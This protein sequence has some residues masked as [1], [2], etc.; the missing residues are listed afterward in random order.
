MRMSK[1]QMGSI[2]S[3][4]MLGLG[5]PAL[6][7][8]SS[9]SSYQGTGSLTQGGATTLVSNLFECANGNS[10]PSPVGE[11]TDQEGKVWTVPA[12]NLFQSGTK[13]ND[14][15]EE[16]HQITPSGL[17]QVDEASVPVVEV[18]PDGEVV[19]GYIFADNYF[20]LYVNGKLIG[21]DSV[22]FTPFNSSIVKFKV[23]KPYTLA[24]KVIDWEENLGLGSER[25]RGTKYHPGDGGF[26]A[27]FSDGTVT[28]DDWQ[29]Q[30]FYTSPVYDL[31]CLSE[32]AGARLSKSCQTRG[33]DD[34]SEVYGVHWP[35]PADWLSE[36]F[37][38]SAWPQATLYSEDDIGVDNKRSYMNF[39][40]QFSGAGAQFIWSSNVV[41]DN[42]VLLRYQVK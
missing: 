8:A 41:L 25:N 12:A 32:E 42:E 18:D 1:N 7:V 3:V 14:L 36:D 22:P 17:A 38:D 16:C 26:I 6:A 33:Q 11:I 4:V 30:T 15:Y 31:S 9:T 19:T 35:V 29:A 13:A 40:D 34:Q 23:N 27:S 24:V 2:L 39:I 21:V 10:R 5:L 28:N 20:E 37:D